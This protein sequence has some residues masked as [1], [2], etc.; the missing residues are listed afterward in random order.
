MDAILCRLQSS[1]EKIAPMRFRALPMWVGVGW[2]TRS[3]LGC[4]GSNEPTE[5]LGLIVAKL[6]EFYVPENFRM[7]ALQV[8]AKHPGKVIEFHP[9]NAGASDT[10]AVE[11]PLLLTLQ[12]ARSSAVDMPGR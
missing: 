12:P 1:A 10:D 7:P 4:L 3:K 5:G 8:P 2:R 6:I 9:Q 11:R